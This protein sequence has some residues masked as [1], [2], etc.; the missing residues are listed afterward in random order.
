MT[1]EITDI[2]RNLIIPL[3]EEYKKNKQLKKEIHTT[4]KQLQEEN[5]QLK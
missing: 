3:V 2:I 1:G 5:K 4:N